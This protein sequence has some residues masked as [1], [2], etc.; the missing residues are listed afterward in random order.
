MF[1]LN[2]IPIHKNIPY[3]IVTHGLSR[4]VTDNISEPII[5]QVVRQYHYH[6]LDEIKDYTSERNIR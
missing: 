4:Y 1:K 5:I 6:I 2:Y 3:N